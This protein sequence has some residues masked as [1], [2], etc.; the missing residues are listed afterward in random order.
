MNEHDWI[1][2]NIETYVAGGLDRSEIERFDLHVLNCTECQKLLAESRT[3][4]FNLNSLFA[5]IRPDPALEDRMIKAISWKRDIQSVSKRAWKRPLFFGIAASV[6]IFGIG[7]TGLVASQSMNPE[8]LPFPGSVSFANVFQSEPIATFT[9]GIDNSESILESRIDSRKVLASDGIVQDRPSKLSESGQ[10]EYRKPYSYQIEGMEEAVKRMP[11]Q[12]GNGIPKPVTTLDTGASS[13]GSSSDT[14]SLPQLGYVANGINRYSDKV[15][16]LKPSNNFD[17]GGTPADQRNGKSN[18]VLYVEQTPPSGT[19]KVNEPF[20][21]PRQAIDG[22]SYRP[23]E[24]Q[25]P[26]ADPVASQQSRKIII[27]TGEIE[28]VIDSFDSAVATIT[29]LLIP[30]KGGYIG[31]VNSEKL[32]N[33]KMKG[34][35]VVRMPPEALDSFVLDL[36]EKLGKDGELKGQRIGS[37]DITKQYTDLESRLKAARTMEQRLLNII[38]EGKGE[39]K[40]LLEAEKE[41]GIWRTKIEEYEGELRF[42]ANQAALSTLTITLTEKEIR[43][44]IGL[45][46]RERVQTGIEVEDVDKSLQQA[47]AA[48]TELKGRISKSELKQLTAGQFNAV[49]QFEVP[50]DQS[51]PMRDRLKQIGRLARLEIDRVTTSDGGTPQADSK[52]KRGDAIFAVQIYNL[53]AIAPRETTTL[54]IAVTDVAAGYQA[55]KDAVSKANGRVLSGSVNAND[56]QN[57]TAQIDFE[58]RRTEE[59]A[60]QTSLGSIGEIFART[61]SRAPESD[62]VTDTKVLYRATLINASKIKP[63]ETTN[64][65][66]EVEDAENA[67][68]L[69]NAQV[70]E[71]K[72]HQVDVQISKERNGN[73]TAKLI[74]DVPLAASSGLI[75]R[76]KSLGTVRVNQNS[77]DPQA[78]DGRYAIGRIDV[79]LTNIAS[80]VPKDEGLWPQVRKGLSYS[81]SML[82]LSVT[83]LIFGLCVLVPWTL[84][85]LGGYRI[86]KSVFRKSQT[87][88]KTV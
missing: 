11:E 8:R 45:T 84:V 54:Q 88:D 53:A 32:S 26:Q 25:N 9:L 20:N 70:N 39:I 16:D 29:K 55:L 64:L 44:A 36:R 31:T 10:S 30:I 38:K 27:R 1:I 37:Q 43:S 22:I 28:F 58:V 81:A 56:R 19:A 50:P 86:A 13:N 76:I 71:L 72:G 15:K 3:W 69:I 66:V 46:E 63:R 62:N 49:L 67:A 75:E 85:G 65:V 52:V 6:G 34:S 77:R 47:I 42:Y 33:G 74:Y 80:I 82:L 35:L 68:T 24:P 41:L 59:S 51:G 12:S 78:S 60:F 17:F 87:P 7:L 48:V 2:E 40:Q 18:N 61:V 73:V 21:R 5:P 14:L 57:I 79:Q 23:N 83:W 4:D